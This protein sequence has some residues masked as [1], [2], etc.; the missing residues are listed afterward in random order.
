MKPV[1]GD[2]D[3]AFPVMAM[4]ILNNVL[5]RADNPGD[6]GTCLTEEVRDLTGARCVL[7]I[8]CLSTPHVLNH[9]VVSVNPLRMSE[10]A[11][12]PDRKRLYEV[13]H[14][15]PAP[16]L[17]HGE[18]PSEG[19]GLL[20][21][22]G[23]ELS[24]VFPLNTGGFCGGTMLVLGLPD[25]EH[26]SSV[27][28]LLSN[29]STIVT[30]VLRNALLYE[31]QEQI[32]Q[33]RTAELRDNNEKLAMELIERQRAEEEVHTLNLELDQRV[34][35]RT[36]QLEAANKELEAFSYTVA[37]DMRAPL[38]HLDGYLEL[39]R[40]KTEKTLDEKSQHYMALISDSAKRMGILIDDFLSF[41]RMGRQEMSRM[42]VDLGVLVEE[43]IREYEM[44]THDRAI[45]WRVEDLPVVSGDRVMLR[46]VLAN[47]IS[48]ALKFTRQCKSPEIDIGCLPGREKETTVFIRDNGVGFDMEYANK[49]FG[50][51]QRLC[52][53]EEYEG[54]GIGLANVRRIIN[55][56]G[57]ETWAEGHVN[58]GATF[59]FSLPH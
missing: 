43:I 34:R 56:H 23:F 26:I 1:T 57:G 21:Q 19:A 12:S 10:W 53:T 59:Y 40:K 44:E 48:N 51:F 38:R 9:R 45:C 5:S 47:L 39:L 52:R 20:R 30:L 16:Q 11:Q 4:D 46:I 17:W 22:E 33:E 32:I 36:A 13:V 2:K 3:P 14:R 54:V 37:H 35:E 24:M 41:A 29:L 31:K 8:Q 18:D 25:E 28:N 50:V 7:L 42:Q 6:L 49:L 58:E 15:M 27:L 55:R